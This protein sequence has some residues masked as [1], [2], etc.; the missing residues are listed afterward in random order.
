[1]DQYGCEILFTVTE[2]TI[3][4]VPTG[5]GSMTDTFVIGIFPMFSRVIVYVSASP[6]L[7]TGKS[8]VLV[9]SNSAF[10]TIVSAIGVGVVVVMGGRV[11]SG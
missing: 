5:G 4:C 3:N 10:C 8:T 9:D 2:S 6:M 11:G 1:M 7:A